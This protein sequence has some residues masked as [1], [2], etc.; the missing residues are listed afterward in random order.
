MDAELIREIDL[1]ISQRNVFSA[2]APWTFSDFV[3]VA[4]WEK[5]R[6]MERSRESQAKRKADREQSKRAATASND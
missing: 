5:L 4:C 1:Q 3:R 2:D 6:K